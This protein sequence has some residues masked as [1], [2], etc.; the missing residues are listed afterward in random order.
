MFRRLVR[1]AGALAV[2]AA[3][4]PEASAQ[5]LGTYSWQ[6]APFCNV[7]TV[8]VTQNGSLYT[9]DGYDNQCGG[10]TRASVTG[11]AFPNPNGTIGIGLSIVTTPNG[12][13]V[14]VETAI[15]LNTLGGPWHD[16]LGNAGDFVFT[17]AGVA[18]PVDLRLRPGS[19]GSGFASSLP[20]AERYYL[21][22]GDL[23]ERQTLTRARLILGDRRLGRRLAQALR[24]YVYGTP[25]GPGGLAEIAA[26]RTRMEVELG[27][28]T[29]GRWHVKFGRGGL[30]DV[31]FLAQALLL[32]DRIALLT[33]RPGRVSQVFPVDLGRPRGLLDLVVANSRSSN[34]SFLAG[35]GDGTFHHP[36]L[37]IR[38]GVGP[39]SL[40]A[41]D[42]N[43]DGYLDLV[44]VN[45]EE[46]N[47]SL[48]IGKQIRRKG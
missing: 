26:V 15:T 41:G 47:I 37:N 1:L 13:P 42:Y 5:S 35:K 24:G 39:F 36:P 45:N 44:V 12:T 38:T 28:E 25:L 7:V 10:A 4:A 34:I 33:A 21:E 9:L 31:E 20:A 32:G 17:P 8:T 14:H 40:A 48:L 11:I 23:W 19:K 46:Q 30:V 27:K 16:S 2:A 6:L 22:W 29:R 3:L 43:Q 18:F